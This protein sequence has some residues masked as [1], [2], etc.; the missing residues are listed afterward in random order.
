MTTSGS[1]TEGTSERFNLPA[2]WVF[3]RDGNY[4]DT[5]TRAM[6]DGVIGNDRKVVVYCG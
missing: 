1:I 5:R 4:R 2:P 6:A 3:Q